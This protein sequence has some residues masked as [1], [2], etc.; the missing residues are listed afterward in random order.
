MECAFGILAARFRVYR[1]PFECNVDKV[2]HI[3]KAT[4]VLHNIISNNGN[5][6]TED[7]AENDLNDVYD[8]QLISLAANRTRSTNKAFLIRENFKKYFNSQ[9]GSV[10]WQERAVQRGRF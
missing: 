2:D 3:V 7:D 8:S 5:N 4:C 6:N 9:L 10:E 1:R